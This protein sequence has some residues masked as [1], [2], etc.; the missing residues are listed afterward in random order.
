M[1]DSNIRILLNHMGWEKNELL[2][3][4]TAENRDEFIAEV[5]IANPFVQDENPIPQQQNP[6]NTEC[7]YCLWD[8]DQRVCLVA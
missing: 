8:M 7:A 6:Q 1:P 3:R 5:N 4:L 2:I